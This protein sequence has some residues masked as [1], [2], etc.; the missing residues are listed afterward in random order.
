M[1]AHAH[2]IETDTGPR[3]PGV[4]RLCVATRRTRPIADMIRFVVAPDG[5]LTPDLKRKLPGRGVWV[6]AQRH[7]ISGAVK[8][9][10]FRRSLRAEVKV[11][12]DLPEL[13]E[14]LLT[15]TALDALSMARK[16]GLAI[17]GFAKVEAAVGS[18]PVVALVHAAGAGSDGVVKLAAARRRTGG[19]DNNIAVVRAFTSAELDLALGR[20]NV[21]HAAL[22]AGGASEMFLARW[23]DL[24]RY[25][26]QEPDERVSRPEDAG[27]PKAALQELG[28]E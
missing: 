25:R 23:R 26:A 20:S 21:I 17:A 22:L 5:T 7:A 8:R 14:G 18:K 19:E 9:G 28:S 4:E 16:A 12:A 10:A 6:S 13:V 3:M 11:P 24:E 27:E 2:D 1:L 15:R